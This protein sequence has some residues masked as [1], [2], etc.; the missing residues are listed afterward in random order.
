MN[1]PAST[2]R[3]AGLLYSINVV[4]GLF[5][6]MYVPSHVMVHGDAAATVN[7]ILASESLFRAGVAVNVISHVVFLLLPLVLYKLLSPVNKTAAVAMVALAVACV[8]ID[9][10]AVADQLDVLAFLHGDLYRHALSGDQWYAKVRSSLD[11]YD[12]KLLIGEIFWGLW[13]LPFGYLV[14]KSGFLPRILGIL[15]MLGY[16]S[17]LISFFTQVLGA[18]DVPGF[19]MLPAAFGEMGIALW[20]LV[21]GVRK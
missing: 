19:V 17:Y 15:L 5:S 16:F 21:F 1:S 8:P 6:L 4:T 12:D 7:H 3:V 9:L 20:L 10:V 18:G 13:L 11:A 2:A 14:F